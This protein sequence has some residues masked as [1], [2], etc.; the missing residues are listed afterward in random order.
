MIL[1]YKFRLYPSKKQKSHLQKQFDICKEVYNILLSESKE[2]GVYNRRD[3]YLLVRDIKLTSPDYY[4]QVHSQVLQNIADRL[5]KSYASFFKSTKRTGIKFS[6]PRFKSK[7]KSITYPQSGFKFLN[8]KKLYLLRIGNVPIV[9]HRPP[10][11]G[12]KTLTIKQNAAGQWFAIFCCEVKNQTFKNH[13]CPDESI[14]IDL[15][16]KKFAALSN[17]EL[18]DNPGFLIKFEKR[19]KFLQRNLSRKKKCSKNRLKSRLQLTKCHLKISNKRLDFLHKIS[20]HLCDEYSYIVVENLKIRNMVSHPRLAKHIYDSSW[21]SF[22]RMLS[23]KA[24]IGEG[25]VEKVDPRNTSNRC[26]NCLKKVYMPLN[27]RELHCPN[28]GFVCDRDIN[29][30][31]NIFHRRAGRAR[32]YTPVDRITTAFPFDKVSELAEAGTIL[33]N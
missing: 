7:I 26:S 8:E 30:A 10:R 21:N 9:L 4:C 19:L 6:L 11:E 28:C 15:G 14:G 31:I 12:V 33:G 24:V 3:L 23:Y 17:G 22:I 2:A 27:D 32:T 29:A 13:P 16:L 5:S 25:V 1:S 20:S 18:I